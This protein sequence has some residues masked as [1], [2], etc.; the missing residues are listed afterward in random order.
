MHRSGKAALRDRTGPGVGL[1]QRSY[2]AVS[3]DRPDRRRQA[4]LRQLASGQANGPLQ[5]IRHGQ[6]TQEKAKAVAA[7]AGRKQGAQ[8]GPGFAQGVLVQ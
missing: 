7:C 6:R 2:G 4:G 5:Q 1:F 3:L 8:I